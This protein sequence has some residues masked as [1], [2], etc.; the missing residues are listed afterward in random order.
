[1]VPTYRLRYVLSYNSIETHLVT[2]W[3]LKPYMH[4][5]EF[6]IDHK[7]WETNL[8]NSFETF[9]TF[10][11]EK[12]GALNVLLDHLLDLGVIQPSKVI[13]WSQVHLIWK[14]NNEGWRFTIYR[15]LNKVIS[16]DRWQIPNIK[17]MFVW[18]ETKK[19]KC[20]R[21]ADLIRFL[22]NPTSWV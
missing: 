14:P 12:L 10:I 3:R 11:K 2:L 19:P 18:I 16:N 17:E 22:P 8:S 6:T 9:I 1:M 21:V 5:M 20:F 15:S 4:P 13:A 7:M